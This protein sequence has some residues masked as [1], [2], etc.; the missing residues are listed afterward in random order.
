M[1]RTCISARSAGFSWG[2][3]GGPC[4]CA[5]VVKA[6]PSASRVSALDRLV[7]APFFVGLARKEVSLRL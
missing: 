2:L 3:N 7:Q 1:P 4:A 6:S 5:C